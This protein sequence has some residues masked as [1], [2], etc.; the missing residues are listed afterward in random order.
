MPARRSGLGRGLEALIP[1]RDSVDQGYAVLA[2]DHIEPNPNQPRVAFD[3]AALGELTASIV[4]V[5]LLQPVVVRPVDENRYELI[6]GERRWRAARR[7]GLV[8]IPAVVRATDD[9][10]TLTEAL[11]ENVQRE[12][13]GPLEEAAAYRQLLEDFQLTHEEIGKRVGKSRTS[14]TNAMRLLQLPASI[15]GMLERRELSAGAA[16]ALLGVDD[17]AFAEHI[18]KRAAED[19]WSVR[20]VEDAVRVRAG[21]ADEQPQQKV[22]Q[23]RPVAIIELEHRLSEHLGTPVNIQY[24]G[25]KGKVVIKFS[26]LD[27]L[28]RIYRDFYS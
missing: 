28:E 2:I 18:A 9:Q 15:Q 23:V 13:L 17:L 1:Q 11:I 20:Q 26:S 19:G 6:A 3:D 21:Q 16:R 14:V 27:E 7:A 10:G 25:D 8:E 12:D 22:K 24:R 5:G 4:E